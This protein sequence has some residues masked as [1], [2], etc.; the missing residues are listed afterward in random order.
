MRSIK[1]KMIIYIGALLIVVCTGLGIVSY[2]SCYTALGENART[3]M[4]QIAEQGAVLI[5][6]RLEAQLQKVNGIA[7]RDIIRDV[8]GTWEG[9]KSILEQDAKE[10]E[11]LKIGIATPDGELKFSD[12]S[13]SDISDMDY[14]KKAMSGQEA[15]SDPIINK[16]DKSMMIVYAVP[17]RNG[18]DIIGAVIAVRD[19]NKL[20]EITDMITIGK[21]GASFMINKQGVTIAHKNRDLVIN[22]DNDFENVETD[23]SLQ[24]LVEI[25]KQMTEGKSGVGEYSYNGV[26]KYVSYHNINGTEW[27]L[28]VAVPKSEM[29]TG[30]Q[31]LTTGII[32]AAAI[33]L[34]ISLGI[35]YL[36]SISI[37]RPIMA[38]TGHLKNIST[39]DFTKQAPAKL[40][41]MT[42]ELGDLAK[43]A[44]LMQES[45][46]DLVNGV[47]NES[48]TV[49]ESATNV[50]A[51]ISE[52][53]SQIEDVSAI[54][55]EL[56]SGM[57]ET[58][59]SAQEMNVMSSEIEQAVESIAQKAQEGA[60][61]AFEISQRAEQLKNN[62]LA[63]QDIAQSTRSD[64]DQKLRD[65]IAQVKAIE[66]I[67]VLSD[68]ILQIASQTNLLALNAAI[69]AARAGEAGKGFSV[70]ADEIRKLAESSRD[71]VNEIQNITNQVISSVEN[72]AQSSEQ[73]LDFIQTQVINDY[74]SMVD[75]GEQFYKDANYINSLVADFSA[76]SEE[77]LASILNLTKVINEISKANN[78][79][80]SGTQDIA[81]KAC[82]VSEKTNS[83]VKLASLT[84]ESSMKLMELI[85]RF[86][87]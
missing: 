76:T 8:S 38:L 45:I 86:K 34:L 16:I 36:I 42:D 68:S 44:N 49:D 53:D 64:V 67:T 35:A 55:E 74:I 79:S 39:G 61:E 57:E 70:V 75:T 14:F 19:G 46:K 43:S 50:Q 54:T 5:E 15:V 24:P 51:N 87:L 59:A 31:S 33:F 82:I 58:S 26:S 27:S 9:K 78:E 11:Y 20:S 73:V 41:K 23:P 3:I 71:T 17:I 13:L 66:Q 1:V 18:N 81:Q 2:I 80:A 22:M 4:P 25:E 10:N 29:L 28:A 48:K 62:A 40:M 6:S 21:T 72:L 37:S 60:K 56:S 7:D 12:E 65:A 30:L 32:F 47:I 83:V 85:S 63:S 69:E 84:K 77:L 52:L